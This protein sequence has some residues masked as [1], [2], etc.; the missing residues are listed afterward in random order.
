[1][2]PAD[3]QSENVSSSDISTGLT[4]QQTE[5]PSCTEPKSTLDQMED[6]HENK[7]NSETTTEA[8]IN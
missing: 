1:L 5:H 6:N 8:S 7:L 4:D 3:Q 2:S